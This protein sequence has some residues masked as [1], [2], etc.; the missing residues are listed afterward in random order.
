MKVGEEA[1]V[2]VTSQCESFEL[3]QVLYFLTFSHYQLGNISRGWE[4]VTHWT[5]RIVVEN[6]ESQS[7]LQCIYAG[8]KY[9]E[10]S[11]EEAAGLYEIA[12]QTLG[13]QPTYLA[14]FSRY[15]MGW[16]NAAVNR[17]IYILRG[18]I[19]SMRL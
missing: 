14:V 4:L 13:V 10:G 1:L 5:S 2:S 15:V 16:L 3:L 7:V 11:K 19:F 9:T 6:V 18:L 12:L 17:L 8:M